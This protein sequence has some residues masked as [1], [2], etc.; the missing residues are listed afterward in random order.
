MLK[1]YSNVI[2]NSAAVK[3]IN[4]PLPRILCLPDVHKLGN[5]MREI[6]A[7]TNAALQKMA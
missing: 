4:P 2:K 5:Y 3:T 7:A 1:E 6:I